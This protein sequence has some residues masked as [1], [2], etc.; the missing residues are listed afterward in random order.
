M[1]STELKRALLFN[2]DFHNNQFSSQHLSIP[3]KF[4]IHIE[5]EVEC[6]LTLTFD[7]TLS[8]KATQC[9]SKFGTHHRLN[10]SY[11]AIFEALI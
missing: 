6:H 9:S 5:Y 10:T 7:L 2:I 11:L 8:R 3:M 1:A 4:R